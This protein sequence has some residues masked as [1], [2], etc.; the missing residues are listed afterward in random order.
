MAPQLN[1]DIIR[2]LVHQAIDHTAKLTSE[3]VEDVANPI[4]E[5]LGRTLELLHP[6]TGSRSQSLLLYASAKRQLAAVE[7][8]ATRKIIGDEWVPRE[9]MLVL[10]DVRYGCYRAIQRLNSDM[11]LTRRRAA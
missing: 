4:A 6:H 7:R 8:L 2:M 5:A 11:D 3:Y 10:V 9:E 1:T